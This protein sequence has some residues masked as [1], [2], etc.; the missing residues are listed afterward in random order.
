[1]QSAVPSFGAEAK[2]S[3]VDCS[4]LR[5]CRLIVTSSAP[6]LGGFRCSLGAGVAQHP[7]FGC[8]ETWRRAAD[9]VT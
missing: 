1:M 3:D 7:D 9:E 4:Q 6:K 2:D 5:E 8:L